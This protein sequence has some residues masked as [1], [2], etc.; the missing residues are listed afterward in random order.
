MADDHEFVEAVLACTHEYR[1]GEERTERVVTAGS[2]TIK[3]V[4]IYAMPHV[5][6]AEEPVKVDMHFIVVGVD[7]QKCEDLGMGDRLLRW[8]R[9]YPAPAELAGGPSYIH[10]GARLGSQDLA[11]RVMALGQHFGFWDVI[12]PATLHIEGPDADDLAGK[13][14]VMISGWS[15]G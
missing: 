14:L 4:D 8:C 10:L 5:D 3:V 13:G 7:P 12:T 2:Q 11:L 6:E 9:D 15:G 1:K